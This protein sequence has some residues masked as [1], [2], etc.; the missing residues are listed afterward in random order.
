[1]WQFVL[2]KEGSVPPPVPLSAASVHSSSRL[3][4]TRPFLIGPGRRCGARGTRRGGNSDPITS[5]ICGWTW[6]RTNEQT[7]SAEWA[8]QRED[9]TRELMRR[10]DGNQSEFIVDQNHQL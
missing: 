1:M 9:V 8:G 7:G 3:L 10:G 2:R 4:D 5:C 6:E